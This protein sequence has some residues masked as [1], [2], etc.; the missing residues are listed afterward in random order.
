MTAYVEGDAIEPGDP[1]FSTVQLAWLNAG[2][3][4]RLRWE[5]TPGVFVVFQE[6]GDGA[7]FLVIEDRFNRDDYGSESSLRK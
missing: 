3:P 1:D 5:Q 4:D 2:E 6:F 7:L